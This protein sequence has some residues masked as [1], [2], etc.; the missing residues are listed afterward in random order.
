M[1]KK[2]F[3]LVK[4]KSAEEG[5]GGRK[6]LVFDAGS[7]QLKFKQEKNCFNIN[8][9]ISF[10]FCMCAMCQGGRGHWALYYTSPQSLIVMFSYSL[11]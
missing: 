10:K 9:L 6:N 5:G 11:A 1:R 4:V 2:A 7:K 8:L 3:N